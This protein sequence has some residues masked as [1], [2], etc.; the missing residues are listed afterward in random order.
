[1]N[2][3]DALMDLVPAIKNSEA[4]NAVHLSDNGLN[5]QAIKMVFNI[6]NLDIRSAKSEQTQVGPQIAMQG[7]SKKLSVQTKLINH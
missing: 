6:F 5:Q 7:G 2:L 3:G 1:M 4:L